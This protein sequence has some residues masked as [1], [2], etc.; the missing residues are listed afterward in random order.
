MTPEQA[1]SLAKLL[2]ANV[3]MEHEI[4]RKVL[5]AVPKDKGDYCPAAPSR[6]ALELAWHIAA[7]DVWFLNSLA[8]GEFLHEESPRPAEIKNPADIAGWYEKQFEPVFT[9]CAQLTAEQ[10]AKP[11]PLFGVYNHPAATYL[12]FMIKHTAHHRGQLAAYLRPMG[13][14]VPNIYGGS[15]DE[16]FELSAQA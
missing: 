9:K 15:F 14:K 2:L 10:W 6:N 13:A 1:S 8:R 3:K 5:Q 7:T 12:L 16:P 4:T 11:L